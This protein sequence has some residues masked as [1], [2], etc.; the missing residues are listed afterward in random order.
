MYVKNILSTH[1]DL[2]VKLVKLERFGDEYKLSFEFIGNIYATNLFKPLK[3]FD[4]LVVAF[5]KTFNDIFRTIKFNR[6]DDDM[7]GYIKGDEICFSRNRL[8]VKNNVSLII[9]NHI[10]EPKFYNFSQELFMRISER[11]NKG[12]FLMVTN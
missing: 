7:F 9:T 4:G 10:S 3:Y 1:K 8:T 2:T 5:L 6:T 11:L 12:G